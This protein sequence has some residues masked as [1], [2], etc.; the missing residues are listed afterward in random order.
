LVT[1]F[2]AR[3]S[4]N[5]DSSFTDSG[6]SSEAF[7]IQSYLLSSPDV[8]A[9]VVNARVIS[10]KLERFEAL[11]TTN[12]IEM[13]AGL[14]RPEEGDGSQNCELAENEDEELVLISDI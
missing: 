6:L 7:A 2:L 3:G 13:Y 14:D 8:F 11:N 9:K 1:E 4:S 10:M 5:S 12:I